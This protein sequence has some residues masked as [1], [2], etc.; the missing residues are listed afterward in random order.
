LP[1]SKR[2]LRFHDPSFDLFCYHRDDVT[3]QRDC[4]LQSARYGA[5][6]KLLI[7]DD[8]PMVRA[9]IAALL[10]QQ[11]SDI[12]TFLAKDAAE[13]ID[14]VLNNSDL[15]A[16]L[17]DITLPDMDGIEALKE[18]GK[19]R[20]DLPVIFLTASESPEDVR[21]G[22]AAG[23]LGYVPKSSTAETLMSAVRLVLSGDVYVPPVVLRD[24]HSKH[25]DVAPSVPAFPLT[26]RQSEVLQLLA[27][28]LSNKEIGREL[29]L[30]ERTVKA[31]VTA[32]FRSLRVSNRGEA[33]E[34]ALRMI[35]G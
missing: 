10:Q 30:S 9:G 11:R 12:E 29:S 28:R 22:L 21:R 32:I 16:V 31:H 2:E 27:R 34:H 18:I 14:L 15:D 5:G 26:R 7:I 24:G 4:D 25:R 23:A 35:D 8:H 1:G 20:P 13:G 19:A 33:I 6:M 3:R 17:L